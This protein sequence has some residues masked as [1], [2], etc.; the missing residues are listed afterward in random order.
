MI[1][2]DRR[3]PGPAI[4][5][6][7]YLFPSNWHLFPPHCTPS[8]STTNQTSH[9]KPS[10]DQMQATVITLLA[11]VSTVN[12]TPGVPNKPFFP[13]A[14]WTEIIISRTPIYIEI[15][16]AHFILD[17]MKTKPTCFQTLSKAAPLVAPNLGSLHLLF[18]RSLSP[19][20][21]D[22]HLLV[23]RE[24]T[25]LCNSHVKLQ[26]IGEVGWSHPRRGPGPHESVNVLNTG[27]KWLEKKRNWLF[28]CWILML[29]G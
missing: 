22:L 4:D 2:H 27:S 29:A 11:Y 24:Q 15:V 17:R 10:R 5:T 7:P 8:S 20:A 26:F 28:L 19:P 13:R 18:V 23:Y 16:T 14:A 12:K 9:H 6:L 21:Y 3:P 1:I 25:I